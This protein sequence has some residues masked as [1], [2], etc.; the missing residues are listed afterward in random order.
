MLVDT[1]AHLQWASFNK[2]RE[3]VIDHAREAGVERIVDIGFDINGSREAVKLAKKHAGIYATVGIHPHNASRLNGFALDELKR[4]AENP[5]V[6]AIGE[7]G[8]DYYR[9]LSPRE[10]QKKAFETQLSLAKELELPVVIH[11]REAHVDTLR[12]LSKFKGRIKV[13]MHCF[14][15]SRE[16]AEEYVKSGFYVSFAGPISFPNSHE[17]HKVAERV[18]LSK[19]LLETDSPW[20]APQNMRGRRNEPAFL[21]FIAEKMAELKGISIDELAEATTENA[22]EAFQLS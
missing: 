22:N 11:N 2:D 8:L 6:V 9:N 19:I 3:K 4:L 12:T 1:H 20:L 18:D 13:I 15:G 16:M 14:S 21:P 5:K 7:I 10:A 17:L